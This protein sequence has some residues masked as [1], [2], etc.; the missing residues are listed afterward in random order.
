ML[1]ETKPLTENEESEFKI[2]FLGFGKVEDP[3]HEFETWCECGIYF[4]HKGDFELHKSV[5]GHE[6]KIL[7]VRELKARAERAKQFALKHDPLLRLRRAA[8][9]VSEGTTWL[10]DSEGADLIQRIRQEQN[11]ELAERSE[12]YS[13]QVNQHRWQVQTTKLPPTPLEKFSREVDAANKYWA[14]FKQPWES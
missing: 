9:Q 12:R 11:P 5:P 7:Q 8:E 3:K 13:L 2:S 6:K 4:N 1:D 10:S 14:S